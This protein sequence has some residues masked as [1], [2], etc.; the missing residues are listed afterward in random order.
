MLANRGSNIIADQ[1][2]RRRLTTAFALGLLAAGLALAINAGAAPAAGEISCRFGITVPNGL[3]GYETQLA[4]LK[5][6]SY[7]DWGAKA[8]PSLPNGTHF[9]QVLRVKDS[10]YP[11][12]LSALPGLVAANPGAHW[13]VGN[14]PDTVR[15]G[16]D[17]VTAEVYADRYY[18]LASQ[19]RGLDPSAHI[20][21]GSIVQPTPIRLRYLDRAWARLTQ[22]AGGET[23]ASGLIDIWSIHSFI[24]NEHPFQWGAGVPPGFESDW[25][26]AVIYDLEWTGTDWDVPETHDNSIFNSRLQ[27]FRQWL[28][29]KGEAG[30]PLWITE[31]GSLFPP[32]DPEGGPNYVNVS[33]AETARFMRETFDFMLGA[34]D[35]SSGL[36]QDGERL[37]QRWYWFSLNKERDTF[38]GTLYDPD[39]G[40]AITEVGTA[41]VTYGYIQAGGFLADP[42]PAGIEVQHLGSGQYQFTG[43]IGNQGDI[44]F[45][46]GYDVAL[47]LGDPGGGGVQIGSTQHVDDPLG[48]CGEAKAVTV[49][50][51]VADPLP[52]D[53]YLQLTPTVAGSDADEGNNLGAFPG[54]LT[55]DDVSLSHQFYP[56]IETLYFNDITSGC[57]D[58]PML[59]CPDSSTARSQMA[60]FLVR[61]VHGSSY[62]P[63]DAAGI[64]S[65]V[66]LDGF[67][68]RYIEQLY[69]DGITQGCAASPLRF[70]PDGQV[71]RAEMAVFLGRAVH[72]VDYTPPAAS[73]IFADVDP[74]THWAADWIEQAYVD[75]ITLGCATDPLRYCPAGLVSRAQMAAFLVRAFGLAMP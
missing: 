60:V 43:W 9:I 70:C 62:I 68:D 73:G 47:Y 35:S 21:F 67:F 8:N 58:H 4:D 16:Q 44:P 75:G 34:T 29:N 71:S 57:D 61:A 54:P 12:T 23:A 42:I 33:D 25:A 51:T 24:L 53:L 66:P 64:F 15:E 20:G 22:L 59:Y 28:M 36:A 27:A 31:Y 5:V 17:G 30:K 3:A 6:A 52:W 41:W 40:G 18:E 48:G 10:L 50:G 45:Q 32:I 72:G 1:L 49:T 11:G 7:L 39:N 63:P 14:E 65:D 56:E 46:G 38:G 37:V 69:A 26:D 19:M 55:F 13:M 74:A 2:A